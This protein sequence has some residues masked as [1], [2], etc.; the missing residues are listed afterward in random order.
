MM[1]P[2][3]R[4]PDMRAAAGILLAVAVSIGGCA[5]IYAVA[6]YGEPVV[7]YAAWAALVMQE[8]MR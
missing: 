8:T 7:Q 6:A 4:D 1:T 2:D 3:E 5:A